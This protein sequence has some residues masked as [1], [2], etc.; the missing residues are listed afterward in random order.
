[1]TSQRRRFTTQDKSEAKD[2]RVVAY[3]VSFPFLSVPFLSFPFLSVPFLSPLFL[4]FVA[5]LCLMKR[6]YDDMIRPRELFS[7]S[8]WVVQLAIFAQF[9][10]PYNIFT[11][12]AFKRYLMMNRLSHMPWC[13][14]LPG[15]IQQDHCH[16]H[17]FQ[18]PNLRATDVYSL[19][20][21]N[22]ALGTLTF[23]SPPPVVSI[24]YAGIFISHL[25]LGG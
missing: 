14:R 24:C 5:F 2:G 22:R 23:S 25:Y 17:S 11:C 19:R 15:W 13:I 21:Q 20:C 9:L 8:W 4:L 1:M 16:G 7:S 10:T 3:L 18:G 6:L 12:F